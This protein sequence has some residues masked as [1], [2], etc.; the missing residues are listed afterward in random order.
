M[1]HQVCLVGSEGPRLY[2]ATTIDR[3]CLIKDSASSQGVEISKPP[4]PGQK[5]SQGIGERNT[6]IPNSQG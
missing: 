1:N 6:K 4:L 5:Q 2:I 3:L